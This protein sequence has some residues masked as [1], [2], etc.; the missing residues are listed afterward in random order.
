MNEFAGRSPEEG[1]D[2]RL[3]QINDALRRL[4]RRDWWLWSSAIIVT[5]LLTV[6]VVS[7]AEPL[8]LK[9]EGSFFRF[10]LEQSVRG[11]IALVLLFNTYT[12]YQQVLIKRLRRQLAKEMLI[13]AGV[14]ARAEEFHKLAM[15][16]PLT[17]LYNR[18]FADRRLAA[19]VARCRRYSY[20]LTVLLLRIN[21][22]NQICDS[23]GQFA[24]DVVLKEFTGRLTQT[25]RISDVAISMGSGEF[26]VLLPECRPEQVEELIKRF[27]LLEVNFREQKISV[28]LS[29]GWAGY[30]HGD[31]PEDLLKRA[32]QDLY[33]CAGEKRTAPVAPAP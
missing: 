18:R 12:I 25:I 33:A 29:A 30:Q 10:N 7:L 11:L 14:H 1:V 2:A 26:M 4:E 31:L 5:L 27:G 32:E 13:K 22:F 19:E 21:G 20:P 9:E 16:D 3:D 17:G 23:F 8:L 6:G 28:T 24:A 15:L